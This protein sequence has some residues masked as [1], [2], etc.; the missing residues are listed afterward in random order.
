MPAEK[1]IVKEVKEGLY[2]EM[3]KVRKAETKDG[4]RRREDQA[5][6]NWQNI[7]KNSSITEKIYNL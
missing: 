2:D 4:T 1:K 7:V 5:P 3:F 6:K